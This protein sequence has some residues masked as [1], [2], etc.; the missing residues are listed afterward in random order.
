MPPINPPRPQSERKAAA[1]MS[2]EF[3]TSGMTNRFQASDYFTLRNLYPFRP[4]ASHAEMQDRR[5]ERA[6]TRNYPGCYLP[7][8][9]IFHPD[10]DRRQA[11]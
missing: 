5:C 9:T 8:G 3:T 6:R 2:M 4:K 11:T 1:Q 7:E 10:L